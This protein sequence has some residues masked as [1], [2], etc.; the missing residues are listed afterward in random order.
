MEEMRIKEF[1]EQLASKEAVPGGGGASALGGAL[2][3]ALG[4]MVGSLTVG[5]KKYAEVEDEIKSEMEKAKTLQEELVQLIN[6]DA[7]AF[8]PLSKAYGLPKNTPEELEYRNKVM[9]T[10]L[11]EASMVPLDIMKKAYEALDMLKVM[12]E[13]GSRIAV[14][15]AGVGAQFCK[16]AILGASVNVFINT[17]LMKDRM[18][19]ENL[20]QKAQTLIGDGSKKADAIFDL[21]M[22]AIR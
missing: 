7:K 1:L 6:D 17:K 16:A 22:D 20:N 13:K 5:K 10:A 15:D 21:V 9:E 4:N 2:G 18:M 8:L 11:L 3:T 14:S 12:A 19:A